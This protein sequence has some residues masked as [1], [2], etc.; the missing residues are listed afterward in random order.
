LVRSTRRSAFRATL[1]PRFRTSGPFCPDTG[2]RPALC[3]G[4]GT[5]IRT[6]LGL[7]EG[8]YNHVLK[9]V[10]YFGGASPATMTRLSPPPTYEVPNH[11]FFEST[12]VLQLIGGAVTARELYRLLSERRR[13][14]TWRAREAGA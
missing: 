6:P 11:A 12:G 7:F 2:E 10:L 8:G 5:G 4:G 1:A 13:G 3:L 14:Q 9:D